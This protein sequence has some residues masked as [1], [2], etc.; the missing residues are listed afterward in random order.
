MLRWRKKFKFFLFD[1][2][3]VF[4]SEFFCLLKFLI[5][6]FL[7]CCLVGFFLLILFWVCKVVFGVFF[8]VCLEVYF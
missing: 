8:R 7:I 4:Y 5:G 2:K 6:V 3:I 1:L